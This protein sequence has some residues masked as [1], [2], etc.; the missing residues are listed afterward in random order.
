MPVQQPARA[1]T[2]RPTLTV[3]TLNVAGQPAANTTVS[4]HGAVDHAVDVLGLQEVKLGAVG[5]VDFVHRL[6]AAVAS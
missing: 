1:A 2:R 3:A 5:V 4:A 6:N